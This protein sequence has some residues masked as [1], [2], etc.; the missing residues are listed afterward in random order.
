MDASPVEAWLQG[1]LRAWDSNDPEHIGRLFTDDAVYYTAPFRKPWRGRDAIVQGWIDRKDEQGD[2]TFRHEVL[3][4]DGDV[5]FVRG[6]TGYK[7]D[8]DYS[9]LWVIRLADDG[10]ASEFIEWWMPEETP[11]S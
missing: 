3:G 4:I 9:N 1:Y 11:T 8:S 5:A 10:R 2:W 6:W 7:T